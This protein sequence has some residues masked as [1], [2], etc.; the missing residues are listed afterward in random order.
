[1]KPKLNL[2]PL[3]GLLVLATGCVSTPDSRIKKEPHLFASLAPEMQV[4][5]KKGEIE[6][7]FSR[8]MVSSA[9]GPPRQVNI[10]TSETGEVEIWTY[11]NARYISSFE[12]SAGYWYRDLAGRPCRSYDTMW[13]N[14]GWFEEYPVLKLEFVGNTLKVME[15]LKR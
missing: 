4:K 11:V 7:G 15:R 10:R 6:I 12:P 5:V 14:R 3:L 13:V 2:L 8:E 9:L 1:M